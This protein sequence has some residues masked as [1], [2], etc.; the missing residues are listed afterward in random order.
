MSPSD[1]HRDVFLSHRSADKD[2]VRILA[3]DIES[4]MFN[5]RSLMTWLDEA[6]IRPGQSIPGMVN[7]GL[8]KSRFI[9][10]V[11]TPAYFNP[12][13]TGWTDAEW[14]AALHSD[15]NNRRARILPLIVADC[16]YIPILLRHLNAI[17]LRGSQYARGMDRLL[18]V[19]REEPLPR[20]ITH[21]GQLITSGSRIDRST[22]IAERAVPDGDPDVVTERLYSNLLPVERLPKYI[23]GGAVLPELMRV[24]KADGSLAMPSKASL[25]DTI[26]QWQEDEQ[27][28][29]TERFMPAFRIFEDRLYTLHDLVETSECPLIAVVDENSAESLDVE[30]FTGD[31]DLRRLFLSLMNMALSRHLGRCGLIIDDTKVHRYYFPAKDG[32]QRSITWTPLK[33]KS[34]RTVAKPIMKDG[35]VLFWRHLG[36]YLQFVYLVNSFYL[37]ISPTWVITDDGHN[38]S[39]GPNIGKRVARWTNP[40]RNLQVMYHIRFWTSVLRNYKPGPTISIRAGDQTIELATV[41]ALIQQSYGIAD[42]NRDLMRLLDEEA[43]TI[44][45][46]EDEKADLAALTSLEAEGTDEEAFI[47]EFEGDEETTDEEE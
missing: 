14:H 18:A 38:A 11:M 13:S 46:Q 10:L 31:E 28:D 21:R 27:I 8:E 44:A 32:G 42:D 6:E 16:P 45:A 9:A 30:S 19:L 39:G 1:F 41:P 2:F 22:L 26:R 4:Q 12:E 43:P 17:D 20:P 35:K 24:R 40:E 36:V 29:E 34:S 23:Y 47:D 25:K 33:K 3:G 15:P 5:G 7:E 37:K